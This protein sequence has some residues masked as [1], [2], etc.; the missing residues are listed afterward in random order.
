METPP[1]RLRFFR[2]V[3]GELSPGVQF[4]CGR[5]IVAE[6]LSACELLRGF[7]CIRDG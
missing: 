3:S 1:A 6:F 7:V 2:E 5:V 4:F